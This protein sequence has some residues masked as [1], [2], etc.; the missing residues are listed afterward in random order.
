M[1]DGK[2]FRGWH[3]VYCACTVAV[4]LHPARRMNT[5][6]IAMLDLLWQDVRKTYNASVGTGLA[7]D[8]GLV[9]SRKGNIETEH[10]K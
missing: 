4:I 2:F 3:N 1:F 8:S 6:T 9:V 7:T 10:G 5:T